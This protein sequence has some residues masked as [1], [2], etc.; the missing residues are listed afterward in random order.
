MC[1]TGLPF[2]LVC[3]VVI[4]GGLS[5]WSSSISVHN[6]ILRTRPDLAETLAAPDWYFDRKGEVRRQC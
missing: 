1:A 3:T 2:R 5:S 4:T 6:E